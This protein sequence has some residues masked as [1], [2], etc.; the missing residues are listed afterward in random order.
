MI[1]LLSHVFYDAGG[2][3]V[4]DDSHDA[5]AHP[6]ADESGTDDTVGSQGNVN[7]D[8]YLGQADIVATALPPQTGPLH[9]PE[10]A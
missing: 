8:V 5:A 3:F 6:G 9:A 1:V 7:E 4:L 10:I 2:M